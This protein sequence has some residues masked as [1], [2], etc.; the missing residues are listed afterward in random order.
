MND[1]IENEN[2]QESV[3]I[4][5]EL[6]TL[7]QRAELMGIKFHPNIGVESLKAK[8]E[9]KKAATPPEVKPEYNPHA[10]EELATIAAAQAL[11]G[12]ETF[13]PL[14]KQTAAQINMQKRQAALRLVR[15]RVT[16][17]N[18]IKGNM[19]GEIFSV[20]N[21]Q[22]GFVKK[23]VPYNAEQGWHVPQIILQHMQQKKFMS[24][25]EVKIGNKKVKKH[26]L[27]PELAIEILPPLTAKELEALK[28]RQLMAA[29]Q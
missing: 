19:K 25:Q 8:I 15:I 1:N 24:F 23:Y 14:Q 26:K 12:V 2:E 18:P 3:E 28:Q 20:G 13:T 27:V 5:D 22:I 9:E 7:K 4:I 6:T 11:E 21:S 16:N 17:M 29:G 10:S